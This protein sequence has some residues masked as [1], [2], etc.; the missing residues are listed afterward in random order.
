[1]NITTELEPHVQKQVDYRIPPLDIIHGEAK[2]L[3]VEAEEELMMWQ[4]RENESDSA[5]D[6]MNRTFWEGQCEALEHIYSLTY[7]LAFAIA[8]RDGE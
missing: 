4:T 8:E 5:I 1:M 3:L 7:G 2:R 6:S